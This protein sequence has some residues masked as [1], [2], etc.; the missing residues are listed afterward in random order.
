[1]PIFCRPPS[2]RPTRTTC[3]TNYLSD[4][5]IRRRFPAFG[6]ADGDRGY[7]E[8]TGGFL[9]PGSLHQGAARRSAAAGR[10]AQHRRRSFAASRHRAA[11]SPSPRRAAPIPPA[12]SSSA[13]APGCRR[14]CRNPCPLQLRCA[15]RCCAGFASTTNSRSSATGPRRFPCSSGRRRASQTI[16]GFPWVGTD[17][18]G[19]QERDR[20]I[21]RRQRLRIRVERN[22]SAAEIA[23]MFHSLHRRFLSRPAQRLHQD[24]G[25]HVHLRRPDAR[26]VID[27]LPGSDNV[28][29]AS[30]CS[31]HGFKHS[32][33]IGEAMAT[34]ALDGRN[35]AL[36]PFAWPA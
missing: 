35:A 32:A 9:H 3:R 28:I 27:R 2:M 11:A 13:P 31:G 8:P 19:D 10:H 36:A 18:A 15:A 16:Y 23:D 1:M 7:F 33:A 17:G 21:R 30:P 25:V 29:V 12:R 5:D 20:A 6:I 34:L 22:V 4:A 24:G 26:F 14:Y